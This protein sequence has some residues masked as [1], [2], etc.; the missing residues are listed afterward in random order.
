M[1]GD[2]HVRNINRGS[3]T[4]LLS[5]ATVLNASQAMV[6]CVGPDGHIAIEPLG[7][8]HCGGTHASD[9]HCCPCTDIPIPGWPGECGSAPTLPTGRESLALPAPLPMVGGPE[10]VPLAALPVALT[11]PDTSPPGI[12]LQV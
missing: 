7:H 1:M 11:F 6:L 10:Y 4:V 3:L 5:L 2:M 8:S 12:V 9:S